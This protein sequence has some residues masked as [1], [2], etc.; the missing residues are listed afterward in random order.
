L[1]YEVFS[2]YGS[3]PRRP[4]DQSRSTPLPF[5]VLTN[6]TDEVAVQIKGVTDQIVSPTIT[7]TW[8]LS[9]KKGAR[10]VS[11]NV[12]AVALQ[13][14]IGNSLRVGAYTQLQSAYA[15]Y[16]DG[17]LQMM[18]KMKPYY[19]TAVPLERF[20]SLGGGGAVDILLPDA[21]NRPQQAVVYALGQLPGRS[22][23]MSGLTGVQLVMA[24]DFTES[25]D[26]APGRGIYCLIAGGPVPVNS[27]HLPWRDGWALN[28][29]LNITKG[30]SWSMHMQVF[31]SEYDFPNSDLDIVAEVE[32]EAHL[33]EAYLQDPPVTVSDQ[34]A[35]LTAV[36]ASSMGAL[37]THQH[38]P[39]G[40]IVGGLAFPEH[41]VDGVYNFFG[42]IITQSNDTINRHDDDAC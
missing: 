24:G 1:E 7:S 41:I 18:N 4:G 20:Y 32:A 8:T 31:A 17:V 11:L 9:L 22:A 15:V 39:A 16:E 26:T 12:S 23:G 13:E 35:I 34:R 36:Y 33:A 38:A 27:W 19:G 30:Q 25:A 3:T 42:A 5:Q 28:R 37:V 40:L 6:T 29:P 14:G 21:A 2:K 10:G